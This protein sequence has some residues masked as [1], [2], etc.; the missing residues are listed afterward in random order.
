VQP[1]PGK[2]GATAPGIAVVG[3]VLMPEQD[4][5]DPNVAHTIPSGT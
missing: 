3:L 2:L 5:L 1:N 4:Q